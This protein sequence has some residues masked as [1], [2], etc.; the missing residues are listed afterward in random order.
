MNKKQPRKKDYIDKH[1]EWQENQFNPGYFTGGKIPVWLH[2]P[3]NRRNLGLSFLLLGTIYG[4]MAINN[5][6]MLWKIK[7]QLENIILTIFTSIITFIFIWAGVFL[8]IKSK[9]KS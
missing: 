8:I 2:Q 3:G 4:I 9:R 1:Q 6:I 5:I 7:P